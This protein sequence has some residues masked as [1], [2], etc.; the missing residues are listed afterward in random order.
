M[1]VD[2]EVDLWLS[3]LFRVNFCSLDTPRARGMLRTTLLLLFALGTKAC[4][5]QRLADVHAITSVCCENTGDDDCASGFPTTCESACADL[6]APF[7]EECGDLIS[8][9]SASTF[10]FDISAFGAF[11]GVCT[12]T[13]SLAHFANGVCSN[14][15]AELQARVQDIQNSCCVQEGVN[16]CT[17][18]IPWTCDAQ[19]AIPFT[20]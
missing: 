2:H 9:V 17:D 15:A 3:L 4:G 10:A 12:H 16:V 11:A 19:C 6:L 7:W 5:F 13:R 20:T 1:K 8:G 14:N 18:G